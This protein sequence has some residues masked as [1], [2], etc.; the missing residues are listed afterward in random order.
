MATSDE[1]PSKDGWRELLEAS[2]RPVSAA[3]EEHLTACRR[4]QAVV[5]ELSD[6]STWLDI[7]AEL[8]RPASPL[9]TVCQQVLADCASR[10]LPPIRKGPVMTACI[11]VERMMHRQSIAVA[12][13]SAACYT[14]VKLIPAGLGTARTLALNLALV[15]DVSG[16]MYEED[17]TGVSRIKRVQDSI[18]AAL[19]KLQPA[20]TL[21]IIAFGHNALVL[22]PPTPVADRAKIDE[23]IRRL[24]RV[25]VDPGGT[26]MD[27]ALALAIAG[28]EKQA[29]AGKLSQIVV[30]TDGETSGE[31]NCR[32][33]AQKAA[34]KKIHLTLMGV[35][36]DWKA[37]LIKDLAH[38]S[39]GKWYYIDVNE[40]DATAQIFDREFA[41]LVAAAFLDVQMHLRPV[42]DVVIKR[43]RQVVPEIKEIAVERLEERSLVARLG[44]LGN[45]APTRYIIDMSLPKR[46]DGRYVVVQIELTYSLGSERKSSG[47]IPLEMT[48][49][50]SGQGYANAEVMKHIDDIQVK[51]L[52]DRLQEALNG[53][54]TSAARQAAEA[55]KK[56]TVLMGHRAD[57]KTILVN[58]VLQEL[59]ASGRV[60]KKTQLAVEDAARLADLP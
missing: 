15:V 5:E 1:C 30:L 21:C 16:S 29:G 12:G 31:E 4:C 41:A 38:I 52:S 55:L 58:Q 34:E 23:V 40:T 11:H 54:D 51:E 28:V 48:Y 18:L 36:L 35:G 60:T 22:L 19:K 47:P 20:D 43:I 7:V 2:A 10:S 33:L 9:P 56:K 17:G 27:E 26:A 49:T 37:S 14:L 50:S 13:D 59:H 46:P 57:K 44:T 32:T 53:S 3:L 8:R 39:Q 42:K 45:D 24:D 6:G 25:E